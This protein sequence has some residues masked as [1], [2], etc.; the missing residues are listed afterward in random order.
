MVDCGATGWYPLRHATFSL[1][2]GDSGLK[3]GGNLRTWSGE[4]KISIL[5]SIDPLTI[6]KEFYCA[7]SI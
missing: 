3:T 1:L 7:L 4:V 5:K 6:P 2:L